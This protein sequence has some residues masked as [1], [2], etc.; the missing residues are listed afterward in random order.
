MSPGCLKGLAFFWAFLPCVC[1]FNLS[2]PLLGL[3]S[4]A[5]SLS[6]G[7]CVPRPRQYDLLEVQSHFWILYFFLVDCFWRMESINVAGV[8]QEEEDAD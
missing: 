8:L 2:L 6:T 1:M 5:T 4:K 3:G 7:F